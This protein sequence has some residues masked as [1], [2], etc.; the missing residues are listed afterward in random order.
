MNSKAHDNSYFVAAYPSIDRHLFSVAIPRA[1]DGIGYDSS[2]TALTDVSAGG[3]HEVSFSPGGRYYVLQY[4]GP[5]VPWQKVIE[6]GEKGMP[7]RCD[8]WLVL[9]SRL[10]TAIGREREV[11]SY[12]QRVCETDHQP[13]YAGE[14]RIQ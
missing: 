8:D 11:E 5:D 9:M 14:R 3:Y 10:R 2:R 1:V 7:L 4:K 13:N 6:A 12:A